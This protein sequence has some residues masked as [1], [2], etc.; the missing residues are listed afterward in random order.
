MFEFF[1]QKLI[2]ILKI[3][4]MIGALEKSM[5]LN[6]SKFY[7]KYIKP[8]ACLFALVC[9]SYVTSFSQCTAINF[10]VT[11]TSDFNGSPISCADSCDAELTINVTSPGGP[12][13]Y[14]IT[15]VSTGNQQTQANPIFT[16][17][18]GTGNYTVTVTDTSQNVIPG[19]FWCES[20][21][22]IAINDPLPPSPSFGFQSAPTC[23][24]SCDGILQG[25]GSLGTGSLTL[26]WPELG[27]SETP[28][29]T[30][31]FLFDLC[32]GDYLLKV[33]DQNGC[34][35]TLRQVVVQPPSIFGN[36]IL[37]D[38]LCDGDCN[39]EGLANGLGGNGGPYT[40]SW[41]SVTPSA[42][43]ATGASS[44]TI[45]CEN[46]T[47]KLHLED[48]DNCPYDTTFTTVDITPI[49]IGVVSTANVSCSYLCDGEITISVSGG[50]GTYSSIEWYGGSNLGSGT[51]TGVTGL[52]N[53]SLCPDSSYYV[54]VT[55]DNGCT[56]ELLMPILTSSSEIDISG[57]KVDLDCNNDGDGSIDVTLS[58]G[59]GTLTPF[60]TTIVPGS[61]IIPN[62]EDQTGLSG[63]T[64]KILVTDDNGCQDSTTYIVV[65]P[66]PIFSNGVTSNLSCSGIIDGS[67]TLSLSGGTGILNTTWTS[68]NPTFT[69]P[70]TDDLT[71]ID[72]GTYSLNIIDDNGCNY[73]T[74]FVLTT[75]DPIFANGTKTDVSCYGF[76]NGLINLNAYSANSTGTICA[77]ANENTDIVLTAPLGAVFTSV[78]FA[79]Y[80]LPNGSCG[81]F[82]IDPA[83]HSNTSLSFVENLVI[84]NNSATIAANNANF[85]DPCIG[86]NKRLFVEA[87]WELSNGFSYSWTSSNGFTSSDEDILALDTGV[88]NVTITELSTLC[89]MDTSITILQPDSIDVSGTSVDI[90]CNGDDNGSVNI[91]VSG[92]NAPVNW[93][94]ASSD[95]TFVDPGNNAT[96]LSPLDGGSYTVSVSDNLGCTKDTTFV[97]NEPNPIEVNAVITNVSCNSL[98]DGSIDIS[99]SG[100]FGSYLFDWDSDG[101]GDNDDNEDLS[102]LSQ[103]IYCLSI[104]DQTQPTCMLDT[105]FNIQEPNTLY[106]GNTSVVEISCADSLNGS[107]D[108]SPTG[109]TISGNYI[110][111]WDNDG[112]GDNDD[113]EDLNNLGGGNYSVSVIDDNGCSKDSTIVISPINT[114]YFNPL[115]DTSNCGFDNGAINLSIN[116]GNLPFTYD[117]DNDGIGDNDDTEDLT[118]LFQGTYQ[119]SLTYN[120]NDGSVCVVDT[121][122]TLTDNPPAVTA[123]VNPTDETC[124][125]ACDGSIVTNVSVGDAPIVYNWSS[126]VAGF[127]ND[128]NSNQFNLCS[129]TYFIEIIDAN[130]CPLFDT[131]VISSASEIVL[132]DNTTNVDCNGD[133]TG[134]ITLNVV[135]GN[136]STSL[137]YQ[138]SWVG[139]N[140]GFTSNTGNINNLVADDYFIT[141]TDDD[142]CSDT[143]TISVL[144]NTLINLTIS[145]NDASCGNNNG[146]VSVVA[147]GGVISGAY[148]YLWE[149]NSGVALTANSSLGSLGS[150]TYNVTVTDDLGCEASGSAI[151]NDLSASTITIDSIQHESC[152][153]DANGMI[154]VSI[155]VSPGPGTLSW[156]G[157][158]GFMD[159]GGSNTTISSLPSGQY[160]ATLTDGLGCIQQEIIDI[161]EAQELILSTVDV[162]PLCYN[163]NTGSITLFVSGGTVVS[164]YSYDWD[165]DG[166]GDLD[167]DQN[168]DSLIS[169]DYIIS[170]YDDFGCSSSETIT[171]NNPAEI[172]YSL[173][174]V[175]SGCGLNDG[176]AQIVV[177]GGTLNGSDYSYLWTNSL[178][179]Q[180][181]ASNSVSNLAAGCYNITVTDDNGCFEDDITCIS[182]PSGPAITL[183]QIDSTSCFNSN[184]GNILISASGLNVPFTF[185]W[186]TVPAPQ[187][188]NL[189]DLLNVSAGTYSITVE[190]TLGCISGEVYTIFQPDSIYTNGV[191]TDLIC[192]NDA[193]GEIDL[194]IIGGTLPF[195]PSWSGPNGY[196][197]N[198]EDLIGLDSGL[199]VISGTDSKGCPIPTTTYN[200]NQPDT[201]V[202]SISST[203][204]A[205]DAPTG[206]STVIAIGGSVGL[207]YSYIWTNATGDTVGLTNQAINLGVGVYSVEVTD[208]NGC[209]SLE[210][211]TISQLTG[212]SIS[213][214]TI[215]PV[216]CA[217]NQT[218]S[219]FVSVTGLATPFSYTWSGSITPDA[220]HLNNED[221]ENWFF[222]T[223]TLQVVDTN[224]CEDSLTNV[225]ISQPQQLFGTS[226]NIAPL[227]A[228]DSSG[229]IDLSLTGG[230][231]PFSYDWKKDGILISNN[232]DLSS[233]S[234]GTYVYSVVDSNGCSLIDSISLVSPTDLTLTGSFVGSTCGNTNGEISVVASGG[235]AT[236]GYNYAWENITSGQPGLSIGANAS[237]VTNLSAGIYQVV[238]ND[239]NSCNDSVVITVSDIDGPTLSYVS[240]NINCFGSVNGAIDLT[241][242]GINPFGFSWVGPPGFGNPITEDLSGLEPGT[243]SVFVTDDNGCSSAESIVVDGPSGPIQLQSTITDLSCNNDASGEIAINIIG[244]TPPY[245]TSWTGPNAYTSSLEDLIGL[246]SGQYVLDILDLNLCPLSGN[247]FDI[248][249]PTELSI[250]TSI[251]SPTCGL[252]DGD[253]SVSVSG[254]TIVLDYGYDWD[255]LSTPN[256]NIS[257]TNA[258]TGIGAGNYQITV[259]DDNNCLDSVVVS[260]SDLTGPILSAVTTDVDCVGDNDGTIDLEIIGS[261]SYTIDWD[262][263]GTGDNDDNEDLILLSAGTYN[264]VV[265]DLT[266]GCQASLSVD[267]EVANTLNMTLT[268]SSLNCNNDADGSISSI[269]NGGTSPY[270]HD[271]SLN[272]FNI[273]NDANPINLGAGMYILELTD[274]NGCQIIDSVEITEPLVISLSGTSVSSSC[275]NSN[276]EVTVVANGG[277]VIGD[278]IYSWFDIGS[279]F[280]GTSIGSGNS[281]ETGLPS[282]SYHVVVVDD[283][284]CT[285]SIAIPVSDNNGPTASW[286][287]VDVLC[288]G[289]STGEIDLTVSGSS[290][291]SF[292]WSGPN[293]FSSSD[294]DIVGLKSGSYTI[295]VTDFNGCINT[296]NI[297]ILGPSDGLSITSNTTDLSCYGNSSGEITVLINGGS[298]PF[299]TSWSGPN[300]FTSLDED[301]IGLDS[302]E[303]VLNITDDAGCELL[304][305]IFNVSQPDS[306]SIIETISS[307]TCNLSDGQISVVVQGG[308]VFTDYQY[309]WDD[310][311]TPVF[312]MSIFNSLTNIGAGNYQVTVTDDNNCSKSAV[313]PI[314]NANAPTLSIVV[315]DIDC[316]GNNNGELD[317]TVSGTSS[318]TVD[319]D[320]DGVGDN[321]DVEDLSGLGPGTYS[322]IINDLSTGCVAALSE[323]VNEPDTI[324]II[325][326]NTNVTCFGSGD[327]SSI[328]S[329]SGG[330]GSLI[331]SWSIVNPGSGL[332]V[333][334]TSQYTLSGGEYKIV[335]IDDNGCK[336]SI[337]ISINEPDTILSNGVV[338]DV[339][340]FGYSEGEIN[341]VLSGGNPILNY[342]WTSTD[343]TFIDPGTTSLINLNAGDYTLSIV[344]DNNC[345]YDTVLTVNAP[346]EIL[347]SA[348]LINV[349]CNSYADG[350]ITLNT[351][352]GAGSYN[353]SWAGPNGFTSISESI[354]NL[355]TGLYV[356]T[357][358]DINGCLKDSSISITQPDALILT[359][360]ITNLNCFNDMSGAI[361]IS[362]SGGL[363]PFTFDWDIDGV[364]D[365]DDTEDLNGLDADTYI[366][367][368]LDGNLCSLKDTF[369]VGQPLELTV[370]SIVTNNLCYGDINGEI[371]I[372]PFGGSGTYVYSWTNNSGFTSTNEDISLLNSDSFNLLITDS[373]NCLLDTVFVVTSSDQLLFNISFSDANCGFLDGAISSNVTGGSGNYIYDWDND[374]TGDNDDNP[375]LTGLIAGTYTL[376]L[377]DDV[378]CSSD[379]SI[380]IS[381]TT[382]PVI[383]IVDVDS[384]TCFGGT[385]GLI[386]SSVSGGLAPYTYLWNSSVFSQDSSVTDLAA[387]Q[388]FLT[389]TDGLGCVAKDTIDVFEPLEIIISETSLNSSCGQCNGVSTISITGGNP[390]ATYSTIWGNGNTGLNANGLC[391]GVHSVLVEDIFGCLS[392][393]NI[394]IS[395]DQLGIVETVTTISPSCYGSSDGSI[396]VAV[397]GGVSPYQYYW[398]NNGSSNSSISN[399]SSG[400]YFLTIIDDNG[401]SK[402][403][404]IELTEPNPIVVNSLVDPSD[405]GANNGSIDLIVNGGNGSYSYLWSNSTNGSSLSNI[406]E[407]LY[408]VSVTDGSGCSSSLAIPLSNYTEFE[409]SVSVDSVSCFGLS[410]GQAVAVVT[411][412]NNPI[413]FEWFD[414]NNNSIGNNGPI[415]NNQTAGEYIVKV[416]DNVTGCIK[417]EIAKVYEGNPITISMPSTTTSSCS[418]VCDGSAVSIVSGG[419]LP[420]SYLWSNG[421]LTSNAVALCE[422]S[423][424]VLITDGNGCSAQQSVTIV[425]QQ[426]ILSSASV[427][428]ANCGACDGQATVTTSGGSGTLD[429]TW[430][431]GITGP[432]HANLCAGVY[433]YEVS[434][435]NG[436][437]T[438]DYLSVNNTNG[439]TNQTVSVVDASCF[440]GSDGSASII[441]IG[442]TPPYTY[443]WPHNGQTTNILTGA[444]AGTYYLEV[445][446]NESCLRVVPVVI[447]EAGPISIQS[448]VVDATCG[449]SDGSISIA[450]YNSFG[451]YNVTWTGPNGF[452]N[453]GNSINGLNS[454]NYNANITN[455]LGCSQE[456]PFELNSIN[457]LF[458]DITV[459][460]PTCSDLCNGE[461]VASVSNGSGGAFNYTWNG[462]AT[463]NSINGLC[464]DSIV[465][466]VVE[467][468]G[469]NC[470][471]SSTIKI[472][473]PDPLLLGAP[474]IIEP[475]CFGVCDGEAGIVPYGGNNI[476]LIN[477]LSTGSSNIYE[478]SLCDGVYDVVVTDQNGCTSQQSLTIT[479]P[480]EITVITD[481]VVNSYCPNQADGSISISVI[482]GDG[483]YQYNWSDTSLVFSSS[484]QDISGLIPG[485]Y[486][487]FV[488]DGN[489]CTGT[490]TIDVVA[491]N[492]ITAVAINDTFVCIDNCLDLT[493]A[494]S[495][496]NTLSYSWALVDSATTLSTTDSLNFCFDDSSGV[497]S[498]VFTVADQNCFSSDTVSINVFDV[499]LVDAGDS[500][501]ELYGNFV[502]LGGSPSGPIGSS[503]SW[504]PSLNFTNVDDT[505]YENPEIE[506]L[507]NQTYTMFVVDSNGCV[508]SDSIYVELIPE[509]S[510]SSGFSPNDDGVNEDWKINQIEQFP[511]CVVEIYN[512]WGH[513][514]YTSD[515]GYTNPWN[516]LYKNSPLPVGTYYYIIELNDPKFPEP[517]TGPITI[518]K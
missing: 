305:N 309:V 365:N 431:D 73:D 420:Y 283:N 62:N 26:S 113:T 164:D 382:G 421:E 321:D 115:I 479:E 408:S 294:E 456:F 462:G 161:D 433:S 412:N 33:T 427:V 136:V 32:S 492:I 145:S 395:D 461:A 41:E 76:N 467:D 319:W 189:E 336:D 6:L 28:G 37:T 357:V 3:S 176:S 74:S 493:G 15:E 64:Y 285:D 31:S 55:D 279:G 213:L 206:S 17:L 158:V 430:F 298:S 191:I 179:S 485:Q 39:G 275:G 450:T 442:G 50:S 12:F 43:I 278:Y 146:D 135:G 207:D 40:Y 184:D 221:L 132:S 500:I 143:A 60:W 345:A 397:S 70:L 131:V 157:P 379:T 398:L 168:Q 484:N 291:F 123:S 510:Y 106:I 1:Q 7:S 229:I 61:G 325:D 303:Y 79:S 480:N 227:C 470:I 196:S 93:S 473:S 134:A 445:I 80:G 216:D 282:G 162:S 504:F 16:D 59:T 390:G 224:G 258:V 300:G 100:G 250:D 435:A 373:L 410:D 63:G 346:A 38:A 378:G 173:T 514:L 240:S 417:F 497:V 471:G 22:G 197:S 57:S 356:V 413:S 245:T 122:I 418:S 383:S 460:N 496:T 14:T 317:L 239:D 265:V 389:V 295:E 194:T 271:W 498:F 172:N 253:I 153:G 511:L 494:G 386:T 396:S 463:T 84:G 426:T 329:L 97:V 296:K 83:C 114:I 264:V 446:D 486:V 129:G 394:A 341:V 215:T 171:L 476:Y 165:I 328:V 44:S 254:G 67:I 516:G 312:G 99:A 409:I 144:E 289:D 94:W 352:S 127:V 214:D 458:V 34:S 320:I 416:T 125:G 400:N 481:L 222:G 273:S 505:T 210:S 354:N 167:D 454:G 362:L 72:S 506:L 419:A 399:L 256:N 443:Y 234:A 459:T 204:T 51:N 292:S 302:G 163:D 455:S 92:G 95:P 280:P 272:G 316:N 220:A 248:T 507:V 441:P 468:V 263:D 343:P 177:S 183:D 464:G 19:I 299:Q 8:A 513:K 102:S 130:T 190:D 367:N 406:S 249:Q 377:S 29:S 491:D 425:A 515:P 387:G 453:S 472:V 141:V 307:P 393:K 11:V 69:D 246:D 200:V 330:T 193:S 391:A 322:V 237:N 313:F 434:D 103:G 231:S 449:L 342:S 499:P 488:N 349:T 501:K 205:C 208:D 71:S 235:T 212:P 288:F 392:T 436:C 503:Y 226:T 334:D 331:P 381:N 301:L 355:D 45:L 203:Q 209:V 385:D 444:E 404:D 178:G 90:L 310:I 269:V 217:G 54:K 104:I 348:A 87:T 166:T 411:G 151:I 372:T 340:C 91:S 482:G 147:S 262:N 267:I 323:D 490:D 48:K 401:C 287:T 293:G 58:G 335:V 233:L 85:G 276:G 478:N 238:V 10:S 368:I 244:G 169:G 281:N 508:N 49:S 448:V 154:M 428:D 121:A 360:S 78:S 252:T 332:I 388:Y 517:I 326:V 46:T 47:Y 403:L 117:W 2:T 175:L 243:Y 156:S 415:L 337:N 139:Q 118:N 255:D 187:A 457:G 30:N 21:Q 344:D 405:C 407:G 364:G 363:A 338:T 327:G 119:L 5:S 314:A 423:N 218:G 371:D 439:P 369:V 219:V 111:D 451:P 199:Y 182:N 107:I 148:D 149:D 223:Y 112:I 324:G 232:E 466:V 228:G 128:G 174:S 438:I 304:N 53:N 469:N 186:Q 266:T 66:N 4:R 380:I 347:L 495:G 290:P 195:N 315:T 181:G 374:G 437:S 286:V 42:V 23:A 359:S 88:Y 306:I 81:S 89:T 518:I 140:T 475:S 160:I 110:F 277:T 185:L 440:G 366:I 297:N 75:P 96:N 502:F 350:S 270:S 36:V 261:G 18:C 65:E 447:D 180:I 9:V 308:T 109:G 242:I 370:S 150:G 116:G 318:Y 483:N 211:V 170:V 414:E 259:N 188:N 24:D 339:T 384:V 260:I 236:G 126:D 424:S 512:R 375:S 230:S 284:G 35:D 98:T 13:G 124:F 105:C 452:S 358:T 152:A 225:V 101:T 376:Y 474:L 86:S 422:G 159:P 192:N 429:I 257:F 268:G 137:D 25:T 477:W 108:I 68:S 201:I 52:T 251:N 202:L 274:F 133:S 402:T 142:G 361:D 120:G 138:Y 487:I 247:V 77:T 27:I 465:S 509:I 82:S 353:W 432:N 311:S 155:S 56:H 20:S 198:D 333:S 241:V 351:S 489:L